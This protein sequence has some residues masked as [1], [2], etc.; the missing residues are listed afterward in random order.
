MGFKKA[1]S[2]H[3][4]DHAARQREGDGPLRYGGTWTS[5]ASGLPLIDLTHP[6]HLAK[7]M[8]AAATRPRRVAALVTIVLRTP[9]EYVV[10]S[11][12]APGQV[13]DEYF[14]QRSLGVLTPNRLCRGVLLLP[15][16]HAD[17][18]RGRRRQA[19]RTNLHRAVSA[20]IRCEL[21]SD[22]RCAVDDASEVLRSRFGLSDA[23]LDALTDVVL[24]GV[25]RRETTFAVARDEDGR[26]LAFAAIV[27]DDT[28]SLITWAVATSHE[29]RWGLHDY[30]VRL[31]IGRR[32]R[33]LLA[34]GGGAFGALGFAP[35]VQH[36]QHLLGYEL[37]HMIPAGTGRVTRRRRICGSVVVAALTASVFLTDA[38]RLAF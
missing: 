34:E 2:N 35:S 7:F 14:N 20:G 13:L 9:R 12:S 21:V 1:S 26:P 32:V 36:Y 29:A 37:R 25:A 27:I 16:N 28:V 24:R 5:A 23:E 38:L 8:A 4:G 22:P 30:V 6:R 15:Q 19:L 33:Y 3:G 18:L 17:Y 11:R 31:L 10:L